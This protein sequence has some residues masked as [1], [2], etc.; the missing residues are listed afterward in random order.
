MVEYVFTDDSGYTVVAFPSDF[1]L[2]TFT[3]VTGKA[4][5]LGDIEMRISNRVIDGQVDSYTLATF[6]DNHE[7]TT[8]KLIETFP[9]F[10]ESQTHHVWEGQ[11]APALPGLER[12]QNRRM[13]PL[14]LL[15]PLR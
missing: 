5:Y 6:S 8:Q 11:P 12:K 7:S 13:L 14:F 3:L 1:S 9:S 4:N 15:V 10:S 2:R